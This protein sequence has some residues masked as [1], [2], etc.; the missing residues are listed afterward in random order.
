MET[1][2]YNGKKHILHDYF[3]N[4][5]LINCFQVNY[6]YF[7]LTAQYTLFSVGCKT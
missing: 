2:P 1:S 5:N 4:I 7:D 3:V 6:T